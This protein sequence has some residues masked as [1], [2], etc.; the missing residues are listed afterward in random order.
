MQKSGWSSSW[1]F[2]RYESCE[3]NSGKKERAVMEYGPAE[4]AA[5]LIAFNLVATFVLCRRKYAIDGNSRRGKVISCIE[6]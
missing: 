5:E 2:R 4:G 3:L 6:Y 1:E